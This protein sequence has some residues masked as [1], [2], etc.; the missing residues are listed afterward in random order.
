MWPRGAVERGTVVAMTA[1]VSPPATRG[2]IAWIDAARALAVLGVVLF[3]IGFLHVQPRL[4]DA[5]PGPGSLWNHVDGALASFRMPMLL[6]LSGMLASGK[7]AR[8]FHRGKAAESAAANYYLYVVWLVVYFLVIHVSDFPL[9]VWGPG[10]LIKQLVLPQ[11]TLWFVQCLAVGVLLLTLTRRLPVWAVLVPLLVVHLVIEGRPSSEHMWVRTLPYYL[12]LGIGARLAP[13]VKTLAGSL[14]A[15]AVAGVGFAVSWVGAQVLESRAL[16]LWAVANLVSCLCAA[17]LLMGLVRLACHWAPFAR[18]GSFVGQRTLSI[19]VLHVP[20]V[21]LLTAMPAAYVEAVRTALIA[22]PA[23]LMVY[24]LVLMVLLA[25]ICL[26]LEVLL[27]RL[28]LDWLFAMPEPL[29][30]VVRGMVGQSAR[31]SYRPRHAG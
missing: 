15:T 16:P 23:L 27:R 6:M 20:L 13:Q 10:N 11:T 9:R 3:H 19:Y 30:E 28:H 18:V 17:V 25:G 31:A 1:P 29:R 24:P 12:Y 14:A 26:G 2:R 7:V 5:A 21:A 22:T 4:A 8:G